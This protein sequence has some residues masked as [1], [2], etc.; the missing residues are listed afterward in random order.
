MVNRRVVEGRKITCHDRRA[1]IDEEKLVTYPEL[2]YRQYQGEKLE[3]EVVLKIVM[4]VY[5]PEQLE[6]LITSHGFE[7]WQRWGGYQGERYGEG[8]DLVIQFGLGR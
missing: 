6:R 1:F 3:E 2:I 5:Y 4:R 8:P 7:I